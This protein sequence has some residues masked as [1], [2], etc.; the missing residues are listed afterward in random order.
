MGIFFSSSLKV[1]V[2]YH[3][4]PGTLNKSSNEKIRRIHCEKQI[5]RIIPSKTCSK[6]LLLGVEK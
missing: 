2:F 3:P 6:K 1:F 5:G 4:N